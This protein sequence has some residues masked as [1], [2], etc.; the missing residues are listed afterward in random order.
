MIANPTVPAFRYDPYDKKFT[1]EGYDH[2]EMRMLRAQAVN[3]ARSQIGSRV[4]DGAGR[5][6]AAG[7]VAT[8][9]DKDLAANRDAGVYT[10]NE[11]ASGWGVVLG[12]LGRQGSLSVLQVSLRLKKTFAIMVSGH[13]G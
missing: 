5:E 4:D 6:E 3:R 13:A 9:A 7:G 10:G 2:D 8:D 11:G 1:A 12:T